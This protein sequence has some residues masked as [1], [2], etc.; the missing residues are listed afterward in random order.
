[1]QFVLSVHKKAAKKTGAMKS[2]V[3]AKTDRAHKKAEV[4]AMMKGAN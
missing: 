3:K 2:P 1:M 4:I